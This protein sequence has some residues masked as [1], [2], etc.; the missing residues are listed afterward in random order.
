MI[1]SLGSQHTRDKCANHL[2]HISNR[3]PNTPYKLLKYKPVSVSTFMFFLLVLTIPSGYSYGGAALLILSIA[4]LR[5][6]SETPC[7][8]NMKR[9]DRILM[10]ILL[11]VFSIS[12]VIT[13]LHRESLNALDQSSR[14]LL[15][16]P[17]LILLRKFPPDVRFIWAGL[18]CGAIG[19]AGIAYWQI[20][21][22]GIARA[23][24]FVTSAIPFGGIALSMGAM[25]LAGLP[26]ARTQGQLRNIWTLILGLGFCA[27]VY[28]SIASGSRGTWLALLPIAIL[29][30]ISFGGWVKGY[31][32]TAVAFV[33]AGTLAALLFANDTVQS[34]YD[35]AHRELSNY[36]GN[37]YADSSIGERLE[38]WRA[39]LINVRKKPLTGWSTDAYRQQIAD[40]VSRGEIASSVA[41]LSNSHN[42]YLEIWIFQGSIGL[43]ALLSLFFYT[44][45]VFAKRIRDEDPRNRS[46]A[47][48][49]ATLV[50]SF[51]SF[52]LTQVI[53]GR[54]NGVMFFLLTL[55]ILWACLDRGSDTRHTANFLNP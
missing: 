28:C 5:G 45:Y 33:I 44:F 23:T 34:R 53:L 8:S 16:I 36:L 29:F 48:A 27:G 19:A 47:L 32:G 15:V 50:A 42:N 54:N 2:I 38:A 9:T 35:S 55:L 1:A 18:A 37:N 46:I 31:R 7:D 26:W 12:L 14:Y 22:Q 13:L 30:I 39:A 11:A 10:Y 43:A 51:S 41:T 52:S 6:K 20:N 3:M 40:Q 21:V 4:A 24:G 49:G 17:I 25:C